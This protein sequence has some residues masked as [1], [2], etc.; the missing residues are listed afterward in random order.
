[1]ENSISIIGL[2]HA[3]IYQNNALKKYFN[4]IDLCDI[5]INK[6]IKYKAVNDYKLLNNSLVLISTP[7]NTHLEIIKDLKNKKIILEKPMVTNMN[8]LNE[9]ININNKN[10]YSS[11][12]YAYG[13]EIEYFIKNINKKPIKIYSYISDNYVT[14]NHIN[15]EQ[16][17]LGGSYLD[18]VINPLSA[19]TRMFGYNIKFINNDKKYYKGDK[20][21]YYSKSLFK[22]NDIDI[23]IEVEW[24]NKLSQKYID[25]IYEDK[26]IRLDSM[27]QQVIDLTNNKTIYKAKGD[28]MTNHYIGV[29]KDYFNNNNFDKSIILHKEFLK[30]V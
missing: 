3:F 24:N 11:L 13:K 7:P 21:D 2:G 28:R 9:L 1:M 8:E 18:E 16:I 26:T 4:N 29:I 19:L 27:N 20:Y 30:G 5:D 25:L 15:N 14:N 22:I 17:S 10:I 23:T 12:H 6:I